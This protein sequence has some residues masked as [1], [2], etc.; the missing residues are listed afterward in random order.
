MDSSHIV[1]L[2]IEVARHRCEGLAR[3]TQRL[4]NRDYGSVGSTLLVEFVAKATHAVLAY[5]QS[6]EK[7]PDSN[8]LT[9]PELE[10]RIHRVSKLIPFLHY[11]LGFVASSEIGQAP[12]PLVSQLRRLAASVIPGSEVVV[13]TRP[14]LNYS[15]LEVAS[16]I[17][18]V[19]LPTPLKDCC[20]SLPPS[21]F[22]ITIPRV[23]STDVLLPCILSHEL[24]HGLYQRHK[25]A[26]TILPKIQIDE[27]AIK[28]VATAIVSQMPGKAPP[29]LEVE[30]RTVIT[31]Q[32]TGRVSKWTQELCS[33]AFGIQL[34]GPSYYFS[35]IYFSLAF[36]HLDK[37]SA[38]HPPNRLR[39]KL[40]N[41]VL[42]RLYPDSC[43]EERVH[44]FIKYWDAQSRKPTNVKDQVARIAL[45]GISA[46]SV[47]ESIDSET[48]G[49]IEAGMSYNAVKYVND[50]KTLKPLLIQ[51]IPPGETLVEGKLI[52]NGLASILNAGWHL[53]LSGLAPLAANVSFSEAASPYDLREKLHKLL[54]KA[55]EISETTRS[56]QEKRNAVGL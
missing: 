8:L 12:Y 7:L 33:D 42:H 40:M 55:L 37:E 50:V 45:A 54:L 44:D 13:T 21:L 15:I 41:R 11:L 25:L 29:L 34:F 32:V 51:A 22:V 46:D 18:E 30:L 27:N 49:A 3:E 26:A 17:R 24:G 38:T 36:T 23:E 28:S 39:L 52:P 56:W 35:F 53:Q 47:L 1:S 10:D 2:K 16:S 31:Q 14:E 20:N 19:L 6:E 48:Q 9:E 5:L 43:F 4:K